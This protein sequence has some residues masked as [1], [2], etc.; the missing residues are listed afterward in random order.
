[1][2]LF[3]KYTAERSKMKKNKSQPSSD[4]FAHFN[5]GNKGSSLNTVLPEE[6]KRES[7]LELN[8]ELTALHAAH[9][10]MHPVLFI[11]LAALKCQQKAVYR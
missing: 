6:T 4:V 11:V 5:I 9:K 3:V 8:Q 10:G 7:P 1:M 2:F